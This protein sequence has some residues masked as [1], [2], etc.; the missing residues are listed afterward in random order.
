[1]HEHHFR[2]DSGALP[3]DVHV[4][5]SSSAEASAAASTAVCA[6]AFFL[7]NSPTS[8]RALGL[9]GCAREVYTSKKAE[10]NFSFVMVT[11][12]LPLISPVRMPPRFLENTICSGRGEACGIIIPICA[13]EY[14]HVFLCQSAF[15]CVAREFLRSPT[16]QEYIYIYIC[17]CV[18]VCVCMCVRTS[19]PLQ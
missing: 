8:R 1:M 6:A 10:H 7:T 12:R 9:N 16:Q 15:G 5:R 2:K 19:V 11:I 13:R 17:V 18:C 14:G 3:N 4:F